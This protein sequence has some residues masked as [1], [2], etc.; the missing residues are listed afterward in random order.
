MIKKLLTTICLL[1]LATFAAFAQESLGTYQVRVSLDKANWLYELNEPTKF[2]IAV[3]LNNSQVAGLPLKY[4]C[5][6]E[7][8]PPIIEKTVT[9]TA[10]PLTID[11]GTLKEA[12]FL[13]CIATVEKDGKTYRGLATAGFRPDLIKPTTTDPTD[14]DKFWN[15]GKAELAKLPIDAK[16]EL[17]TNLSTPNVD[18][19]QVNFQN[20]GGGTSRSSRIY[21]I[22]AI[23]KSSNPNAKFP[24]LLSVPGAG[25]RPYT[26][27]IALAERGIITL[28]IGIHGI[29]VNLDQR[30]YD[31]LGAGALNRYNIAGNDNKDTYYYK[32]VFL[33]AVRAN[34][35]LF[36]L[37]Q[38]DGKNLGVIGGSQGGALAIS[39]A[40][41]DSRVKA[42]VASYPALS[43]LT[44]YIYGRAGGWHHVFRSKENQTKEK[45]ETSKYY[46]TVNFARRLKIPGIYSWGFNDETCPPTSM[47]SA[48]NLI[49]APK[50]LLLGLEM[51][52]GNS[53]EQSDKLNAWIEQK[54]KGN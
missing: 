8:M 40:A 14:F 37:P 20:V 6:M 24:A 25:V 19:F 32:R 9:T 21:G 49:S 47:Y 23:P 27:Q 16:F 7:M 50:T 51:G 10:Q 15:D 44:G 1:V 53:V 2:T 30:V 42:L 31:N 17:M 3:T 35:F 5:G 13:R 36:T 28:Q 11:G 22:L 46:D 18:V 29:P 38:F 41:L 34:D 33:G 43:D 52:H 54:L 12:G 48:Y 45:I 26:G 4:S 39:T